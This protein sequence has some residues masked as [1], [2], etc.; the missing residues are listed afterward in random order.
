M[1]R[2]GRII[3]NPATSLT[4]APAALGLS[5]G[6]A[7]AALACDGGKTK[8]IGSNGG[9]PMA[10]C[11]GTP[12]PPPASLGL[13]PFYVK[14]LDGNGIPVLASSQP[15]DVAVQLA[16]EIVVQMLAGS[17]AVREA[18]VDNGLRV[19]VIGRN[20]V[21][22]DM[23]EHRDLNSVFPLGEWDTRT[24][25]V[26]AT[27]DRPLSSAGE[28]NLLCLTDDWFR[29][30]EI[31]V[32]SFAHGIRFLGIDAIDTNFS[33]RLEDALRAARNAGLWQGTFAETRSDQYYAE[34]VQSWFGANGEADPPDGN[35]NLIDTRAELREYDPTL[36]DLIAEYLPEST[37][38]PRCP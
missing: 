10:S 28:E 30:E 38:Q 35:H 29:G 2:R 23:P 9:A 24:R 4:R 12:A 36:A 21:T 8:Y 7:V 33:N 13:D 16:C 34:G 32:A 20:E 3:S 27:E 11:Q 14:Y 37:W 25:G 22:T 18:A 1:R 26:G 31:L 19:A 15:S 17:D 5:L 6:F